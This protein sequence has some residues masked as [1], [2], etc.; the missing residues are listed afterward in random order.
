MHI[1]IVKVYKKCAIKKF[2]ISQNGD[3]FLK[4][5]VISVFLCTDLEIY[6]R[7]IQRSFGKTESSDLTFPRSPEDLHHLAAV[8]SNR[9][10]C[11]GCGPTNYWPTD[12]PRNVTGSPNLIIITIVFI[13]RIK[14]H[15]DELGV[16]LYQRIFYFR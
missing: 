10:P 5:M 14:G 12:V 4:M 9:R 2:V 7:Y 13:H 6:R 3:I 1:R 11:Q 8:Q 16:K 15:A